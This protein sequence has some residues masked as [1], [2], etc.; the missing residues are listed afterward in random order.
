[1]HHSRIPL[2]SSSRVVAGSCAVR[3]SILVKSIA[4]LGVFL[5]SL[6]GSTAFGD[7]IFAPGDQILGGKENP[8]VSFDIG[9]T[10]TAATVNNWPGGETP[11][12]AIDGVG[13]KYLN[14]GITFTGI[15]VN[16]SING[17]NGSV[18]SSMQLWTAND[19]EAR[20]PKSYEIWGTNEVLDFTQTSFALSSF[21]QISAGSLSLP[22]GR[23]PGGAAALNNA[24]S[25]TVTFAN[26]TGYKEYLIV[27]PTV[28]DGTTNSM[29]IGE[30]QLFGVAAFTN[31]KWTGNVSNVWG[32]NGVL[33]WDVA[34]NPSAYND[35]NGVNFDDSVTAAKSNITISNGGVAIKPAVVSFKNNTL[36]YTISGEAINSP[37][38]LTLG[39]TGSVTLNN[40]NNYTSGTIVTAGTLNVGLTGTL[41][42]GQLIVNNPN[43]QAGSDVKVN[44]ASPQSIGSLS[45]AVATP[46]SGTNSAVITLN[47]DLQINQT[48]DGTYSGTIAGT[49]ALIK[50]GPAVL[51]LTGGN[52]FSGTITINTGTLRSSAPGDNPQGALPAGRA[53]VVN[54][55]ATL[56]FGTD[57]GVGYYEGSVASI[58]VN[59][60]T[61]VGGA[62]T[63]STLPTL[64]LNGGTVTAVG[65]G[66]TSNGME[67]NYILDGNVSTIASATP[68]TIS[69]S[70][71]LL[72]KNPLNNGTTSPVTFDVARGT[73]PVDLAISSSIAD[74]G[75]GLIKTGAGILALLTKNSYTGPTVVNGGTVRISNSLALGLGDVTLN[76]GAV[77]SLGASATYDGFSNFALNGGASA[78]AANSTVTLTDNN[79]S[80]ARS[81]FSP[82]TVSI[83]RGFKTSFVYTA[84]GNRAADGFTFT[85]QNTSPNALGGGGGQ[86]GY[87]GIG[88]SAA[89]EFNIYTGGGQPIGTNY[90]VGTTG[91]YVASTPVNLGS[92]NPITID[93]AYD[94]VA[95]TLT[96]NL[97][98]PV[99]NTSYTNVFPGVDLASVLGGTSG[100]VGF[101]GATGG[102][103]AAQTIGSF[104]FNN[105]SQGVL[106]ANNIVVPAGAAAGLEV[107]PFADGGAGKATLQGNLSLGAGSTLNVT[108][109]AT[110]TDS[111]YS[112]TGAGATIAGSV[113]INVANN[114]TGIGS[115]SLGNVAGQAAGA[116]L[117]KAGNGI[118]TITGAATY[119]GSTTVNAG[120]LIVN[121]SIAGLATVNS[122]AILAGT[123]SL[124]GVTVAGGG[125]IAPGGDAIGALNTGAIS[126]QGGSTFSL[127]IGGTTSDQLKVAGAATLTGAINLTLSLLA[128]PAEG[129]TFTI[130]DGSAA[131]VGY[132]GG[133]RLSY[134][135][136]PL[137]QDQIF[138]VVNGGFTQAFTLSYT[139]DNNHDI[140]L[141]AVP[142]PAS[143]ASLLAGLGV[144][145]GLRRRRR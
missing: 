8:G 12:H 51:T 24:N 80:E 13:Q 2:S 60:G 99:A 139:A 102:A 63:H 103:V 85:I 129:S 18:A 16:P 109:G 47:G 21:T 145:A 135:G 112:L 130:L 29:Q 48:A 120:T 121:G 126:L 87:Q 78:D 42:A 26:T 37:G 128:D 100:Y 115:F 1:M 141:M 114:G 106:L 6:G 36:N 143:A 127:Q 79:G 33:N 40:V 133:A 77:L 46:A 116:A 59:G 7:S 25:Q 49:G 71:I 23:G 95:Q 98:D 142:E 94:P 93:L 134:L 55:G 72:R 75:A 119:T 104:T 66:N 32:A 123:G 83:E 138:T 132:S 73:A 137:A 35:G 20:D 41:G 68:S 9:V 107:V 70:T 113:T 44:F 22:A 28:K 84:S 76:T 96:E 91:A 136:V 125:T 27:F 69:A 3:R 89:V 82:E 88:S 74:K 92:G 61:V 58:T 117:V 97:F 30:I 39:G 140:V 110:A 54:I 34:G 108:G 67:L 118:L 45:G 10:G 38:S 64:I 43:T 122:G 124:A 101:T 5:V 90:A 50:D 14:F 131:L 17:G 31:L 11:D 56:A 19:A 81:V 62:N 105:F 65:A 86:L 52:T 144:L 15:L 53:V 111:P 4:P 57:D